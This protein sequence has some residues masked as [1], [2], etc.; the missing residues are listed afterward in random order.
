MNQRLISLGLWH[1]L[2]ALAA[3]DPG[4]P[5][6]ARRYLA[7]YLRSSDPWACAARGAAPP[8]PGADET[9]GQQRP[10]VNFGMDVPAE[11]TLLEALRRARTV[12]AAG[13]VS[14]ASLAYA[15]AEVDGEL[16]FDEL[17]AAVDGVEPGASE[18]STQGERA[19]SGDP[20]RCREVSSLPD[21]DAGR[22]APSSGH[23]LAFSVDGSSVTVDLPDMPPPADETVVVGR[24]PEVDHLRRV[25]GKFFRHNAIVTGPRGVG[26]SAFMREF[27]RA[28]LERGLPGAEGRA[29]VRAVWAPV[30]EMM[31]S[32]AEAV[33]T[34]PGA[35]EP[36]PV[37]LSVVV[38]FVL[39]GPHALV[40]FDSVDDYYSQ[41]A[42]LAHLDADRTTRYVAA[43]AEDS[44]RIWYS[45]EDRL[46][47]TADVLRLPPANEHELAQILRQHAERVVV[48]HSVD[49]D[50]DRLTLVIDSLVRV[51][52][53]QPDIRVYMDALDHLIAVHP[54]AL[55]SRSSG[56]LDAAIRTA[57]ANREVLDTGT[58]GQG[59]VLRATEL[60][61]ELSRRVI[62]QEAA[63]SAVANVV[64]LCRNR[65][66][67]RPFRADGVFLFVG[68]SGVGKTELARALAIVLNGSE[69]GLMRLDMSEFTHESTVNRLIGSPPGYLGSDE[70]SILGQMVGRNPKGVLLLDEFE[71]AHPMVHRFFLQIFDVGRFSDNRGKV[72]LMSDVTIIATSN[73]GNADAAPSIGFASTSRE[74][75]AQ[76][77]WADLKRVFPVELLNRFDE[78][79]PFRHLSRDVCR[80]I[81]VSILMPQA[82]SRAEA[83]LGSRIEVHER[84]VD[85][86]IDRGYDPAF[87]L[88]NIQRTLERLVIMPAIE[89]HGGAASIGK[90][91]VDWRDGRTVVRAEQTG[92]EGS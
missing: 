64:T 6:A 82:T 21:P 90:L 20:G 14:P 26:K 41:V 25:L 57:L 66:D 18:A 91:V 89:A 16:F 30:A 61:D 2:A 70:P 46:L 47:Q 37:P 28:T 42:R 31:Q 88:R 48:Q 87:G 17:A 67:L 65:L 71:K 19:G 72:Y 27:V 33:P 44:Y 81:V 58:T 80:D 23:R 62:G 32:E 73:V 10:P 49:L 78:I 77:P 38:D 12:G 43:V 52:R 56:E 68:P 5:V 36:F 11:P 63:V 51:I 9:S 83:R 4:V 8:D 55:A 84:V 50:A 1:T 76:I 3:S 60:R 59:A 45:D 7:G 39:T 34:E 40:V 13:V 85:A 75:P 86:L 29:D 74:E 53:N 15:V 69:D 24:G 92:K 79:V 35:V 54:E 22:Y